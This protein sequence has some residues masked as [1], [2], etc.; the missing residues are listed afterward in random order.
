MQ[1]CWPTTPSIVVCSMLRPFA[2]LVCAKF[3]IGKPFSPVQTYATLLEVVA[4]VCK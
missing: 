4:S 3:E 1:Y 2:H